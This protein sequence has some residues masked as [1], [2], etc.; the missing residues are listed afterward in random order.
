MSRPQFALEP[1]VPLSVQMCSGRGTGTWAGPTKAWAAAL[2]SGDLLQ[3]FRLC[4][5]LCC[6]LFPHSRVAFSCFWVGTGGGKMVC[7]HL[8]SCVYTSLSRT[9]WGPTFPQSSVSPQRN[10]IWY[11]C[12]IYKGGAEWVKGSPSKGGWKKGR[13]IAR[14]KEIVQQAL[15]EF[16]EASS[17]SLLVAWRPERD[18]KYT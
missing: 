16:W 1:P 18:K 2:V 6:C 7:S 11:H 3:A 17:P 13:K 10:A 15:F 14:E 4:F 5:A 12:G 8:H 9:V